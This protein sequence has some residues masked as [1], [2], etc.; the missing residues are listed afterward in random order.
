M[1]VVAVH[2]DGALDQSLAR[3]AS[4]GYRL[5]RRRFAGR[6]GRWQADGKIVIGSTL[7][8]LCDLDD[9]ACVTT[10]MPC[11]APEPRGQPRR[12]LRYGVSRHT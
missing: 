1:A 5:A 11:R 12:E 7:R 9:P 3:A 10:S 4:C 6:G 8:S 2:A